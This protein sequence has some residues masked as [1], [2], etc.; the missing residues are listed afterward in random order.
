MRSPLLPVALLLTVAGGC[1]KSAAKPPA[2][3]YGDAMSE[4]GRRFERA[5]RAVAA[6]RWDLAGY[7]LDELGEVFAEDLPHAERPGDVPIDPA[8]M[9]AAFAANSLPALVKA[10]ETKD[11]AAFDGAFARAAAACN[12]CHAS[13]NKAFIEVAP[14]VGSEVPALAT[15]TP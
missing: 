3:R 1:A 12:A 7:D 2:R 5:G 15:T 4:I 6:G 8:P 14:T 9:A 11:R 10:V 13:T